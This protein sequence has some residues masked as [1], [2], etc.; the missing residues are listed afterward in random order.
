[1]PPPVEPLP[2]ETRTVGQLVAETIRLYGARFF[3]S[4]ALGLS[5][6]ALNQTAGITQAAWLALML[7][8]GAFAL[9]LSFVAAAV[10]VAGETPPANVLLR[11]TGAGFLVMVP[12]PLLLLAFV[13]PGVA[14]LALVGLAVPAA[15]FERLG[16]REALRRGLQLGRVDYVHALGSMATFT[17]LYFL[18]RLMLGLLLQG[19]GDQT[20]RVAAFLADLVIAPILFLGGTLLYFDQ[21]ARAR[22]RHHDAASAPAQ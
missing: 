19:Q 22:L 3:P 15:V 14:W 20:A 21:E 1:M 10:I 4:L 7:T 13:L 12:F 2:P 18:T 11:A 5:V 8:A 6:A 9:T 16:V 17:I